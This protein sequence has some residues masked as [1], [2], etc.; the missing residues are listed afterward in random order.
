MCCRLNWIAL[1]FVAAALQQT[2]NGQPLFIR[3]ICRVK[4]QETNTLHGL[5]LVVG[6]S[7]TGDTDPLTVR[8]LAK[9]VELMGNPL[10]T[11]ANG[12]WN[13]D[14]LKNSKNVALVTVTATIPAEGVRQG[15]QL[16]CEVN[17]FSAKSLSGGYLMLTPL[18]G[19]RPDQPKVYA[20][21]QG[22]IALDQR[23]PLT[24]G[25]IRGGC[26]MEQDIANEFV[27]DGKFT[28]VLDSAHASFQNAYDVA[29]VINSIDSPG[30]T[31]R[32]VDAVTAK[33]RD[34]VNVEVVIPETYQEH[35]VEYVSTVLGTRI[36]PPEQEALVV[37]DKRNGVIIV[38]ESVT[39]GRVAVSHNNI[40]VQTGGAPLDGNFVILP[41]DEDTTIPTLDSLVNSL[42]ALKVST[43]DIIAIIENLKKSGALYGRIVE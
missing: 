43:D 9:F 22:P 40:A 32:S 42:N 6:L 11:D 2:A 38:G 17:A 41:E 18:V 4:G 31:S 14:D 15:D 5:G 27:T 7:G 25:T 39:I 28:L 23:G 13:L 35:V 12:Q 30:E 10:P 29:A 26:R 19:P 34:A 16:E 36:I 37:I 33:A 21:C 1:L 8:A 24:A 3:D 20:L